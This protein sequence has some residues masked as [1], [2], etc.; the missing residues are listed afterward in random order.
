MSLPDL[1]SLRCVDALARTL[2]FSEAARS[3]ALSPAAFSARIQQA[4]EQL[5]AQLFQRTTRTVAL[6]A[7]GDATL[8]GIR[9][10]LDAARD[11]RGS[12]APRP[13]D[14]VL[15]TRHELGM[16]W[17][18]PARGA[19]RKAVP[20]VTIHLRFG[21]T[22]TLERGVQSLALD[23]AITSRVPVGDAFVGHD[24]HEERYA[25]VASPRL[26]KRQPLRRG[27]EARVHTLI[28]VDDALPLARY[29][30]LRA[31]T[32]RFG[33]TLTL[34]TLEAVRAAVLAGEGVAVLPRYY[35]DADLR[36]RRLTTLLPRLSLGVDAFRLWVRK[37]DTRT[38]LWITVASVLRDLPLR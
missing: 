25:L 22:D 15:G 37:D 24:L 19:L 6:T 31:P 3:V 17:L 23:G 12:A 5:G 28:D 14:L 16:S 36:R 1:E 26:L 32:L 11:L 33:G 2:R 21:G 4:E 7:A 29:A 20:H 9:A 38:A 34:G 27:E 18:F 8:P 10:I 30:L 35:I 13:V